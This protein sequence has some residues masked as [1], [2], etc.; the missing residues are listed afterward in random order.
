MSLKKRRASLL[1][2]TPLLV[3]VGLLFFATPTHAV[4][5]KYEYAG[6]GANAEGLGSDTIIASGGAYKNST[7]FKRVSTAEIKASGDSRPGYTVYYKASSWNLKDSASDLAPECQNA[8]AIIAMK[9]PNARAASLSPAPSAF[10]CGKYWSINADLSSSG[11][12]VL[13]HEIAISPNLSNVRENSYYETLKSALSRVEGAYYQNIYDTTGKA[14]CDSRGNCDDS[15]WKVFVGQCWSEARSQTAETARLTNQAIAQGAD[16]KPID[17]TAYAF[18]Q[19]ARC[20]SQKIGGIVSAADILAELRKSSLTFAQ[21]NGAGSSAA[22]RAEEAAESAIFDEPAT[23]CGVQGIGWLVCPALSFVG[24]L[25]DGSFQVLADNLLNFDPQLLKFDSGTFIA[26]GIFRN[27]AN[28]AFVI[29]FLIIIFSQMTGAGVS[30][31]GVKKML[32]RLIIAAILVNISYYICQ[33]A[34]DLSNILGFGLKS[35]FDGIAVASD[36]PSSSDASGNGLGSAAIVGAVIGVGAIAVAQLAALVPVL[37]GALLAVVLIVLMLMARQA[38]IVLLIVIAPLAFVAFLLPNTESVFKMW[39]KIFLA[40]LLIF[41]IVSVIF[42]ASN[43]ASQITLQANQGDTSLQ[44]IAL[45]ILTVPFFIVPALL[46]KSL[47]AVGGL[48]GKLSTFGGKASGL[49]NHALQESTAGEFLK[50]RDGKLKRRRAQIRGGTYT[51]GGLAG[52]RSRANQYLNRRTEF[53]RGLAAEGA[54]LQNSEQERHVKNAQSLLRQY[55][56]SNDERNSLASGND[57][58][59]DRDGRKIRVQATEDTRIAAIREVMSVGTVGEM[60][61]VI[62]D[63]ARDGVSRRVRSEVSSGVPANISKALHF[64]GNFMDKVLAGQIR[65]DKDLDDAMADRVAEGRASAEVISDQDAA[66]LKRMSQIAQ[67]AKSG[68]RKMDPSRIADLKNS[69]VEAATSEKLRGK[70]KA[71]QAPHVQNLQ[72]L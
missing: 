31:Y 12:L 19:F 56:L 57:I 4:G 14:P 69:A 50:Y 27:I 26:W 37:L 6:A 1:L 17:E 15:K 54:E 2:F 70:I 58:V 48:S 13:S 29:V 60:E 40:L 67:E 7:T 61:T 24:D 62:K 22:D 36:I 55:R 44:I 49:A 46:K 39:R 16:V 52:L 59:I 23:S 35:V 47:D 33:I 20:L 51:G 45:G 9:A 65:S 42:G 25:L 68:R 30:S 53:G 11:S 8:P 41:P 10:D 72:N 32:P 63:S 71:N 5:E 34:V 38:L 21:I 18:E 43:L 3:L 66:S 64:S 28:V